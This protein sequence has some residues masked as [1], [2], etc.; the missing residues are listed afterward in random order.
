MTAVYGEVLRLLRRYPLTVA[1]AGAVFALFGSRWFSKIPIGPVYIL[2][3]FV[4]IGL[5]VPLVLFLRRDLNFSAFDE[6]FLAVLLIPAWAITRSLQSPVSEALLRD[7]HPFLM[8]IYGVGL[9]VLASRATPQDYQMLFKAGFIALVLH[10][11]WLVPSKIVTDLSDRVGGIFEIRGDLDGVLVAVLG[12]LM[13]YSRTL[14]PTVPRPLQVVG[15]LI[16]LASV[17]WLGSRSSILATI[18]LVIVW[19]IAEMAGRN[20]RGRTER[21]RQAISLGAV[22]VLACVLPLS[23]GI[24]LDN[25]GAF[26]NVLGIVAV[27]LHSVVSALSDSDEATIDMPADLE[28]GSESLGEVAVDEATIDMPADLEMGSESLGEVAV[29]EATM[30]TLRGYG[31]TGVARILSWQVLVDYIFKQRERVLLGTGPGSEYLYESGATRIL[32]GE[33]ASER[34]DA[35]RHPHNFVLHITALLGLPATLIVLSI[36]A[37]AA[38]RGLRKIYAKGEPVI[39]LFLSVLIGFS[40]A[41]LFGVIFEGPYGSVPIWASAGI[42]MSRAVADKSIGR[43]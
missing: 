7:L 10:L 14:R 23:V 26:Q 18:A 16:V 37:L 6:V 21:R 2:D 27:G 17:G 13:L 33:V 20:R 5:L 40:V 32:L 29:D 8:A 38:I 9:G 4:L 35:T 12:V 25:R 19:F 31:G 3:V 11:V 24:A 30:N 34:A 41:S 39:F 1:A 15:A 22:G 28:M 42:L 36:F 43:A